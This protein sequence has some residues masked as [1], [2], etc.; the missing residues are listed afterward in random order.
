MITIEQILQASEQDLPRL[1]GEVLQPN[2]NVYARRFKTDVATVWC[3]HSCNKE[4]ASNIE[5]ERCSVPDLIPLTPDNQVKWRYWARREYPKTYRKAKW[6]VWTNAAN[7]ILFPP[8]PSDHW[9]WEALMNTDA[10]DKW[11]LEWIKV[12]CIAKLLAEGNE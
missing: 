5:G 11:E 7:A 8:K 1:A 4:S 10:A 9:K 6:I 3:C 12:A 2:H